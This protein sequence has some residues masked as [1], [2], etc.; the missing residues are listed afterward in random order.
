MLEKLFGGFQKFKVQHQLLILVCLCATIPASIVELF[1]A[2]SA[3]S[4]LSKI[5]T[6][7]LQEEVDDKIAEFD[8]F[9]GDV[10]SDVL[11]MS[12]VPAVQGIIRAQAN[13]GTD[14]QDNSSY[15]NWVERLQILFAD[16]MGE[17]SHYMQ[18]RYLDDAGNELVQVDVNGDKIEVIPASQLQNE[19]DSE[20]FTET[21]KSSLGSV[22]ISPVE[23]NRE[24]GEIEEPYNPVIRY[25]T[26]IA[27]AAG[28][29]K[30]II[31]ADIFASPLI[32][33]FTLIR[34][35]DDLHQ[36]EDLI[37][38]NQ[39]GY[40]IYHPNPEKTWG[41]EFGKEERLANDFAP[42]VVERILT[43]ELGVIDIGSHLLAHHKFI[44]DPEH[45]SALIAIA[46]VPKGTV[47]ASVRRF[48]II[49][50]LAIL[51]SLGIGIPFAI[52]RGR[53][54]V[55]LIEKLAANISTSSQE[56]S[57]TITEQERIA[58][59][60][61]ASVNETTTTMDELEASSRHA[62]DQAK[63]A[64]EA[65][66]QAFT[67]SEEGAQAVAEGLEGMFVLEQ[68]VEAIAGQIVNLSGQANQIGNIS[69]LV[70]DFANQT[71]MLALNSS[72]EAVRAGEYGKGFAVVANEIRKLADQSQQSADK[73]NNLVSDIQK[74]INAT[75]MVTEEGTKTV[76]TGVQIAKRTEGAFG[77][78]KDAVNQVVLNNQ[79]VSLNLKQQVDAIQQ[80]VDAMEA[81]NRG[82][83]ETASGLSQTKVGTEQL[84]EA[85]L[86]LQTMV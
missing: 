41:F 34:E 53:Q 63:A 12:K 26:P 74:S 1:G 4:S 38:A 10:S 61:A 8:D 73:I 36:N 79:Q 37:L 80:V 57:T 58:S 40:Y 68:K 21:L 76:K 82:A 30:G 85:A 25:S 75:V 27:N 3:T 83:K 77:E 60:Q 13:G 52:F 19:A 47:F 70:S 45:P 69:Q 6:A 84:N 15:D 14:P 59:Q 11:F 64:V 65:A 86:N 28:Q 23:L 78:V 46:E 50:G 56:M 29:K 81:I 43:D 16:I 55:G 24:G 51:I 48:N 42:D 5:A 33:Q 39:D 72:V 2:L 49:S 54:L 7:T 22:Y 35:T 62:A 18:L 31:V 67:A 9:L 44:P 71:N 32:E 66:K 17:K 20:Y